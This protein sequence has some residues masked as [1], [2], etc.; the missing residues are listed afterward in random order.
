LTPSRTFART[1]LFRANEALLVS[2][3][4][5]LKAR[6]APRRPQASESQQRC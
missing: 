2:N 4:R 6:D 1:A 3:R 5:E